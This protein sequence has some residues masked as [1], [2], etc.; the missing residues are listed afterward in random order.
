MAIRKRYIGKVRLQERHQDIFIDEIDISEISGNVSKHIIYQVRDITDGLL[1]KLRL[2]YKDIDA[3]V[4]SNSMGGLFGIPEFMRYVFPTSFG[5]HKIFFETSCDESSGLCA[6]IRAYELIR[7]GLFSRICVISGMQV[8]LKNIDKLKNI[9]FSDIVSELEDI[10]ED[11]L[12]KKKWSNR[13]LQKIFLEYRK[14]ALNNRKLSKKETT[15]ELSDF[16]ELKNAVGVCVL[17]HRLASRTKGIKI[18]YANEVTV[19]APDFYSAAS[20]INKLLSE[21][22]K[23][24][25]AELSFIS[26]VLDQIFSERVEILKE[27]EINPSGGAY[28]FYAP[29]ASSFLSLY[30]LCA[31]MKNKGKRTGLAVSVATRSLDHF[32]LIYLVNEK[33][34]ERRK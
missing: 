24:D 19:N 1:S 11:F 5:S 7:S 8:N 31:Y 15:T 16:P 2:S 25:V 26:P 14:R 4:V 20:E 34:K 28:F 29:P 12:S 18:D 17:S 13:E 33:A 10:T 23:V 21:K 9:I 27:A 22:E 30:F 6:V 32:G 3:F